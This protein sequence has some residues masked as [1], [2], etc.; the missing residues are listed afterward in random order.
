MISI[1]IISLVALVVLFF[2]IRLISTER[3]K[4]RDAQRVADM[5]R[6]QVAFLLLY[7]QSSSYAAAAE[8]GCDTV[9]KAVR[10][11]NLKSQF[12]SIVTFKDPQGK[13]YVVTKVP[14]ATT[15]E[16]RFTL[17]QGT[18]DLAKGNHTLSPSGIR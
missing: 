10:T 14:D 8:N 5:S 12:A 2:G 16:I 9:G 11:C 13:D 17:E 1:V 15:Y 7:N 4:A 3:A 6:L 18:T